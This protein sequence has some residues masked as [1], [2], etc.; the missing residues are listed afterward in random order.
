[1]NKYKRNVQPHIV[2]EFSIVC[3]VQSYCYIL[4][5]TYITCRLIL[6]TIKMY[7]LINEIPRNLFTISMEL[8]IRGAM[9]KA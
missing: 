3:P 6:L 9:K 7:D 5:N 1:M 2:N 4:I 8:A